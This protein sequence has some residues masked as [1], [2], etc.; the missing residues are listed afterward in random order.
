MWLLWKGYFVAALTALETTCP[1]RS[2][3]LL[4]VWLWHHRLWSYRY[5]NATLAGALVFLRRTGWS[6][7]HHVAHLVGERPQ[8]HES[9]RRGRTEAVAQRRREQSDGGAR[10]AVGRRG[11]RESRR[12]TGDRSWRGLQMSGKGLDSWF[13]RSIRGAV[14]L[15]Y[16]WMSFF[17]HEFMRSQWNLSL[18]DGLVERN[19]CSGWKHLYLCDF[20]GILNRMSYLPAGK[21]FWLLK[22][23]ILRVYCSV[24]AVRSML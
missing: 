3:A 1:R 13:Q 16:C 2:Y 9:A 23:T 12:F 20:G 14:S 22:Q 15:C 24:L 19:R 11:Q 4:R 17:P 10:R 6:H 21:P 8:K 5:G 18:T 7:R